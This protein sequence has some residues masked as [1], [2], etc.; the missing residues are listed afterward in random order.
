MK[1]GHCSGNPNIVQGTDF[2]SPCMIL[3]AFVKVPCRGISPWLS[4]VFN[5]LKSP[6][7]GRSTCTPDGIDKG[8]HGVASDGITSDFFQVIRGDGLRYTP[9]FIEYIK[10]RKFELPFIL[11][12]YK[13]GNGSLHQG[14]GL[15]FIKLVA[16]IEFIIVPGLEFPFFPHGQREV[17]EIIV[18]QGVLVEGVIGFVIVVRKCPFPSKVIFKYFRVH[19]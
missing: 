3:H 2:F 4:P 8:K 7:W 18:Q 1:N 14:Q 15:I 11:R 6:G 19:I 17:N 12:E 5:K 13:P 16:G 10:N 9:V